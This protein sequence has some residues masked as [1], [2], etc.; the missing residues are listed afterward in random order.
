MIARE[1]FTLDDSK[2]SEHVQMSDGTKFLVS[3]YVDCLGLRCPRPQLMTKQA[4]K[5]VS[6]GQVIKV[7]VDSE[8]SAEGVQ[9]M[10]SYL[11]ATL[12]DRVAQG[13]NWILYVRHD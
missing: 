5:R 6:G 11:S 2:E 9:Q 4:L 1:I 10:L 8:S 12:L 3:D 7:L 13:E